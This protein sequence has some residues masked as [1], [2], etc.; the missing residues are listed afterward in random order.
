MR[1]KNQSTK[2][3]KM[4]LADALLLLMRQGKN[5]QDINVIEICSTAQIGR[6]TYYRH[7]DSKD[8]KEALLRFKIFAQWEDYCSTRVLELTQSKMKVL[9]NFFYSE[10][11]MFLLLHKNGL[12]MTAI[13]DVLYLAIGPR[14][15]EEKD[16]AYWK[17]FLACSIFGIIYHWIQTSFEDSPEYVAALISQVYPD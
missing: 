7:F 15:D 16:T 17:A 5:F 14:G 4:C 12:T 8:G 13:F 1:K 2:F 9:I 6:T 10:K 11:E 3:I